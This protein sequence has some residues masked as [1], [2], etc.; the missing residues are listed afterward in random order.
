MQ[1]WQDRKEMAFCDPETISEITSIDYSIY[2][3]PDYEDNP[4]M[5]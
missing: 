2:D 3:E 4:D 1:P 5:E